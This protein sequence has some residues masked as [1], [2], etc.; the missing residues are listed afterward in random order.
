MTKSVESPLHIEW[1]P[2]WVR[3]QNITTGQIV[4]GDS[5]EDV[6]QMLSGHRVAVVGVGRS[7]VFVKSARLPRASV[8]DLRRILGV[9][10]SQLFPLP[11]DQLAF[12]FVQTSDQT[13]EGC[14]TVVAA[15]RADDL[16]NLRAALKRAGISASRIVPVSLA[17]PAVAARAG[18]TNALVVEQQGDDLCLDVVVD[19]NVRYSRVTSALTDP[20]GEVQ[21]T[22][23]ASRAADVAVI[24]VGSVDIPNS[25]P[26]LD[27]AL[28]LLH[29]AP[30][31]N[32]ELS[33]DRVIADKKRVA[34]KMRMAS[35][36]AAAAVLLVALVWSNQQ[37][38]LAKVTLA[39]GK[40]ARQIALK[41]SI[42]STEAGKASKLGAA[43]DDLDRAFNP[44]QPVSD[45]AAVVTDSLPAGAWLTGLTVE[46]GK[47]LDIRGA[48]KT[49]DDVGHFVDNLSASP[50]FRDVK[51]VFANSALIGKEPVVQ[52]N[53]SA[54]GVGNLPMPTAAKGNHSLAPTGTASGGP[55]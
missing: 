16:R 33:E 50:R 39:Q 1:T 10:V 49:S 48:S 12:D 27:S 19:G 20:L 22:L 34:S 42:L 46:R 44:A 26:S 47:P 41:R 2:E 32:F 55:S 40:I 23:A 45:I 30:P 9:Q 21:R 18:K 14:L 31:F 11:A 28:S 6:S 51:L 13:A 3:V 15:M 29:L 38:E 8:E 37:D 54:T 17:T 35:L 53:I 43:S 7:H 36:M 52:F 25:T 5:F 24:A 4:K